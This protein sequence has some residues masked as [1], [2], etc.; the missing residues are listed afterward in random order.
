MLGVHFV[1]TD[2]GEPL[3][4]IIKSVEMDIYQLQSIFK[5]DVLNVVFSGYS[6]VCNL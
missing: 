4:Y 2:I 1:N 5:T 3:R 6:E